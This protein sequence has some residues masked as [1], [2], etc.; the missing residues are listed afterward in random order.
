MK[1]TIEPKILDEF[2]KVTESPLYLD[3]YIMDNP[4]LEQNNQ[5]SSFENPD[6]TENN[7][8]ECLD[9]HILI[10]SKF[11]KNVTQNNYLVPFKIKKYEQ[12]SNEEIIK[13]MENVCEKT[14]NILD[15]SLKNVKKN[16]VLNELNETNYG[17]NNNLQLAINKQIDDINNIST[18]TASLSTIGERNTEKYEDLENS[19]TEVFMRNYNESIPV[20]YPTLTIENTTFSDNLKTEI[21]F[22]WQTDKLY[23]KNNESFINYNTL[24]Q[25]LRTDMQNY[26]TTI[27]PIEINEFGEYTTAAMVLFENKEKD[28]LYINNT[29]IP[30]Y[31]I[32]ENVLNS[33]LNISTQI[34]EFVKNDSIGKIISDFKE[35]LSGINQN[36]TQDYEYNTT[37]TYSFLK[38]KIVQE[39][40]TTETTSY[41]TEETQNVYVINNKMITK[42][43]ETYIED[44]KLTS[45]TENSLI[46]TNTIFPNTE[47][48]TIFHNIN[49]QE[50]KI[51][52]R[53]YEDPMPNIKTEP[54]TYTTTE[55]YVT[56]SQNLEIQ[57]G[58]LG[59][60]YEIENNGFKRNYTISDSSYSLFEDNK[61]NHKVA[62]TTDIGITTDINDNNTTDAPIKNKSLVIN[63][64]IYFNFN[65]TYIPAQFIQKSNNDI[66][67][68]IDGEFLCKELFKDY[69]E[70]SII[71]RILCSNKGTYKTDNDKKD[72]NIV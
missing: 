64:R 29:Q 42:E 63:G 30:D 9:L 2:H 10:N 14:K 18:T 61:A 55:T 54:N 8:I 24:Q 71:I 43:I 38:D 65:N 46:N 3:I 27:I 39:N 7:L 51:N 33:E 32:T 22:N 28:F 69:A 66:S 41:E 35:K 72:V 12:F 68:S 62:T 25:E 21:S 11:N 36:F 19:E 59:N 45:S 50:N 37:E 52:K 57:N 70:N 31:D 60:N 17:N 23:S 40:E 1:N 67:I 13:R 15:H 53:I 26:A 34:N 44:D 58:I 48:I 16:I 6:D 4:E 20:F 49:K 5:I 56:E 47:S